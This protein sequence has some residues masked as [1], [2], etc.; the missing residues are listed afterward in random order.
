MTVDGA[1]T[2]A[3]L[4]A[5]AG[6]STVRSFL[7]VVPLTVVGT[8][9]IA[10]V[11]SGYEIASVFTTN[12]SAGWSN[13]RAGMTARIQSAYG[14]LLGYYRV[15][16]APSGNTL[17]IMETG[18]SDPGLFPV[19]GRDTVSMVGGTLTVYNRYDLWTVLPR[20]IY[21][22]FGLGATFYEDYDE[23][24]GTKN[25]TPEVIVN[26]VARDS[27][28]NRGRH[29]STLVTGSGD[30]MTFTASVYKWAPSDSSTVSYAWTVPV[31]WTGV[32]GA[33][34][35][36]LSATVPV[37]H[38]VLRL[39]VTDSVGGTCERIVHVWVHHETNYP[40]LLVTNIT[41]DTEDRTGRRMSFSVYGQDMTQIPD[42]AMVNYWESCTW[43]GVVP[44]NST[45]ITQFPGW[46]LRYGYASREGLMQAD[47]ELVGPSHVLAL[48][49]GYSQ[50]FERVDNPT[51]WQ[52]IAP[53]IATLHFCLFHMMRWRAANL[54]TLFN[55]TPFTTSP[56]SAR[57]PVFKVDGGNLLAQLQNLASAYF[58]A[59]FGCDSY[60]N[61]F[62]RRHP[63]LLA[64]DA[65]RN[66]VPERITLS[67]STVEGI[68]GNRE[69]KFRVRKVRGEAFYNDGLSRLPVPFLSDSPSAA[70]GQGTS[71][72]RLEGQI[73][74]SGQADLNWLTG[75]V[76]ALENNPLR[77]IQ[78]KVPKH[79]SVISP[80][81]MTWVRLM[82][83]GAYLPDGVSFE[84]RCVPTRV[85]RAHREDGTVDTTIEMEAETRGGTGITVPV[86]EPRTIYTPPTLPP[87]IVPPPVPPD[88]PEPPDVPGDGD[89]M[90]TDG[91]FVL[92][93]TSQGKVYRTWNF[94][95]PSP[96]YQDISP[97]GEATTFVQVLFNP[98]TNYNRGA[99]VLGQSAT[100]TYVYY[101]ANVGADTV[102][103][104]EGAAVPGL[105]SRLVAFRDNAGAILLYNP[106]TVFEGQELDHH[107]TFDTGGAAYTFETVPPSSQAQVL[108]GG[109]PNNCGGVESPAQPDNAAITRIR[110]T[111]PVP[112]TVTGASLDYKK[113]HTDSI[114]Y[115]TPIE[116]HFDP[117]EPNYT[118]VHGQWLAS[119]GT[120][121]AGVMS[122]TNDGTYRA[123]WL[124]IPIH[125]PAGAGLNVRYKIKGAYAPG[126]FGIFRIN[127]EW[128][129]FDAQGNNLN[130]GEGNNNAVPQNEWVEAFGSFH[131][132]LPA[133]AARIRMRAWISTKP[134]HETQY[135]YVDHVRINTINGTGHQTTDIQLVRN[136]QLLDS[137]DNVIATVIDNSSQP[138]NA[139]WLTDSVTGLSHA[140]VKSALFTVSASGSPNALKT[141]LDNA[142][143]TGT[144]AAGAAQVVYSP[145]YGASYTATLPVGTSPGTIGGFDATR[146]GPASFAAALAQI[147]RATTIGGAYSN[148]SGG[149]YT[150][151]SIVAPWWRV[152]SISVTNGAT[153]A[154]LV[155]GGAFGL[156]TYVNGSTTDIT[157]VAGATIP[158]S[159][160]ITLWKGRRIAVIADVGGQRRL[161]MTTNTGANWTLIGGDNGAA[162]ARSVRVRR[163]ANV[164]GQLIVAA[165][166]NGIKYYP[167]TGTSLID[168]NAP[169][170]TFT[171]AEFFG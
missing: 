100:H 31:S 140:N 171:S 143:L 70:P 65:E 102:V 38:H 33:N 123:V 3:E 8:A 146:F 159:M 150:A 151:Q 132:T 12:E 95:S 40:P 78:V 157:P 165:G 127:V 54:L 76:F 162:D 2:P 149:A 46:F 57:M 22:G 49:G 120:P 16:R 97:T 50:Y 82:I 6:P 131:Y 152:G 129:A 36:V 9:Q 103:W 108:S 84:R 51:E 101:T 104:T 1:C 99:Y 21:P 98:A 4:A 28:G 60:G 168:K 32:S 25:T 107:V 137:A 160:G 145:D 170:G 69:L 53:Q 126:F 89:A 80:A 144:Y 153:N 35:N 155:I 39:T 30:A 139:T 48:L 15:R 130:I 141:Y 29:I 66:A 121:T 116:I 26:I 118:I 56:A 147:K 135:L 134:F 119:G 154:D 164:P 13:V 7:S 111:L 23:P 105:Y 27:R 63:S 64:L 93:C 71:D 166:A 81:H 90:K 156:Y 167:G 138:A 37:G 117:P 59:N 79:L 124:E 43:N 18:G 20:I 85:S 169:T 52:H 86:P 128:R 114:T 92:C 87:I 72:M 24:V 14:T 47:P 61:F 163:L 75:N 10:G 112:A 68:S 45:F 55:Y 41:S 73:T 5:L 17:D 113:D 94:L 83:S 44:S 136:V 96:T 11:P 110:V 58:R 122:G 133:D 115:N 125:V 42:G 67:P 158:V 161:Y 34:T 106:H 91:S 88:P 19:I 62:H 77:D 109:N 74:D 148:L 142:I